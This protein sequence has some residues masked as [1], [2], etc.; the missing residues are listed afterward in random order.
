MSGFPDFWLHSGPRTLALLPLSWLYRGVMLC[1]RLAYRFGLRKRHQLA[2]PVMVI[3]NI[4]VGGTGK[5]PLVIWMTR[6]LQSMKRRPGIITRGYG[7]QAEK[8]PQL[9][10]PDSDPY[11]VGDEPVLLAQRTGCPVVASPNRVEA[12]EALLHQF[13]CDVIV[14][15]DGLQH[16]ALARDLEV[17][18]IDAAR[19]L[20]NGH[21][22]PAGPLREP[23]RRLRGVDLVV[24]NGGPSWITHYYFTL[25]L[26][27]AHAL[28]SDTVCDLGSFSGSQVHAVTGIGNPDRFFAALRRFGIEVIPH[29]F[30]DHHP[31]TKRDILFDDELPVLM[32]EKDAVKCTR[33][34]DSRHW[35]VPAE[36][37]LTAE[38]ERMLISRVRAGL[39]RFRK[40]HNHGKTGAD[41]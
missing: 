41:T 27:K 11:E 21:C 33:F 13:G 16:Y 37:V 39:D 19:G 31:F 17:V 20:G 8:W 15:D 10:E 29:P 34:A 5:T 28:S 25:K 30:A 3:G 40:R 26:D 12:A 22:L 23:R 24:A 2:V 36:T 35:A 38:T 4:F 18:V 7:G 32:T 6:Y 1:R 14:S 9:V